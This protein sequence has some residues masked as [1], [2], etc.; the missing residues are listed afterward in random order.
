M[1][2]FEPPGKLSRHGNHLALQKAQALMFAVLEALF[3]KEL[4]SKANAQKG[5]PGLC[6]VPDKAVQALG[7]E[8]L[9]RVVEGTY[10]GEYQ[11]VRLGKLL[12]VPA[13]KS[14]FPNGGEGGAEGKEISHAVVDDADHY[15]TPFVEGMALLPSRATAVFKDRAADLKAPSAM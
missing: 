3:K 15:S 14:L 4:H 1:G 5:L 13:D 7:P 9:R 11:T 8:L 10:P 2:D 6:L 12:P